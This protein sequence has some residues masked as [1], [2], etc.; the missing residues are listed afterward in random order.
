MIRQKI[1]YV[2]IL[3]FGCWLSLLYDY[4]GLQFLLLIWLCVPVLCL[5]YLAPQKRRTE[6][7]FSKIP[8]YVT[9]GEGIRLRVTVTYK[10]WLPLAG[11]LIRG[12]WKAYGEKPLRVHSRMRGLGGRTERE[13]EFE[14]PA[15][16]CGPAE[17]TIEGARIYDCLCL[18]SMSV[19]KGGTRKLL[20]TPRT[21]PLGLREAAFLEGMMRVSVMEEEGDFYV[22]DYR[23]GDSPRSIH[24]KLTAKGDEPQVKDVLP[25]RQVS[26]FLNRTD[27][28][29]R[30][31]GQRDR[32][33]DRACSLMVFLSEVCAERLVV[34]WM[35]NGVLYRNRIG[36]PE[37]IYPCIRK[38]VAAEKTGVRELRGEDMQDMLVGCHLEEDGRL[39]LGEYCIDE[40]TDE[41]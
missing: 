2:L 30:D 41:E 25:D 5:G 29:C 31:L 16:H 11:L 15:L 22:R 18:F 34:C 7:K 13:I 26:L 12:T 4:Q 40:E 38:L 36:E 20:I 37:D 1:L 21:E 27:S 23:P 10:G 17:F 24:W 14:L 3:A 35:Q 6:V 28:L 9:R 39:W 32:F 19:A 8:D 33:L